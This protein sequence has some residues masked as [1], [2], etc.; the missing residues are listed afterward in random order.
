MNTVKSTSITQP[1]MRVEGLS[2]RYNEDDPLAVDQFSFVMQ[3]GE[4]LALLG[5]SG[6][7]KTTTLR[8]LAGFEHPTAGRI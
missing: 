2:K 8:M 1:L 6:C 5:P 4:I 3:P 7:G